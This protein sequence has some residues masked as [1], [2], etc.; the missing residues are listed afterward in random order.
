MV[1]IGLFGSRER[2]FVK[3]FC[4]KDILANSIFVAIATCA[5][6]V[7]R[8][9]CAQRQRG[10]SPLSHNGKARMSDLDQLKH[11]LRVFAREREWDQ[12]HSPKNL[13]MALSV[14][15]AELAEIFQ[16]MTEQQSQSP[17]AAI[18]DAIADEVADI[19]L[20]L[21]RLADKLDIDIVAAAKQKFIKNEHK[22]PAE[23]VRGSARKYTAYTDNDTAQE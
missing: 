17:E 19:Q 11:K 13:A 18:L 20:Y 14:E 2:G 7:P 16:W 9:R 10:Q 22:Y 12:F 5:G 8:H 3:Q 15:V 21:I 23:K 6:H 1:T 4:F